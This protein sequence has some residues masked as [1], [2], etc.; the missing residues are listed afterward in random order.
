MLGHVL[1]GSSGV[2]RTGLKVTAASLRLVGVASFED[3]GSVLAGMMCGGSGDALATLYEKP[4]MIRARLK[5]AAR[6]RLCGRAV[7]AMRAGFSG[8]I[9]A[10]RVSIDMGR[11]GQSN[12]LVDFWQKAR[13]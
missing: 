2:R 8:L 13:E 6:C 5:T 1:P 11:P 10:S 12:G 9:T 3:S 7:F 4:P